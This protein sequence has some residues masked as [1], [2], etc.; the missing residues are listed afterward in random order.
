MGT[1]SKPIKQ[2]NGY[3]IERKELTEHM[4][5]FGVVH[6]SLQ[7]AFLALFA[8]QVKYS[9]LKNVACWLEE[10]ELTLN[11]SKSKFMLIANSK[12]LKNAPHFKLQ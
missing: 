4:K 5:E 1:E 9:D 2:P 7:Y 12:K 6:K 8:E 10:N 11:T 3:K